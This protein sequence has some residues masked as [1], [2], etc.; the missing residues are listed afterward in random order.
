MPLGDVAEKNAA[1]NAL[2]GTGHAASMASSHDLAL[3]TGSPYDGGV[4]TDYAGY[5]RTAVANNS[6]W[7]AAVDGA[8]TR[9][10]TPP[11]ATGAA[12]LDIA[13]WVLFNGSAITAWEFLDSPLS[14]DD[15]GAVEAIGV[16]VYIPDDANVVD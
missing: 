11:A 13:C 7:P 14:V 8:K 2:F 9:S 16:T 10:V 12:S 5:S 15:A 3:F 6:G 1:L 4:E